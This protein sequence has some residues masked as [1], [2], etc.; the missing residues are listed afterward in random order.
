MKRH[1][2]AES[3]HARVFFVGFEVQAHEDV[4]VSDGLHVFDVIFEAEKFAEAE[5]FEHFDGGFLFTD[6]FGFDFFKAQT[7]G[8]RSD[9]G[10]EGAS[11]SASAVMREDEHADA[12]D[13]TFPTAEL[14]VKG[15]ITNDFAVN[16]SEQGKIAMKVDVLAPIANDLRVLD[17]MFDKHALGLWNGGKEFVEYLFVI[18]A[19]RAKFGFGAVLQ[20]DFFGIFLKFEFE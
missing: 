9:F 13:V 20:L 4:V 16:D 5:E 17:A 6:E 3:F 15:G 1:A 2:S 18:F 8:E 11:E 12:A 10:N 7:A 14:L 19:K